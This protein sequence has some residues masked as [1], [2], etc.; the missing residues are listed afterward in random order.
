[1]IHL[2]CRCACSLYL[3]QGLLLPTLYA[4]G[5][6]CLSRKRTWGR[7]VST[8]KHLSTM[9]ILKS[10]EPSVKVQFWMPSVLSSSTCS[11]HTWT[12]YALFEFLDHHGFDRTPCPTRIVDRRLS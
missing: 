1:M 11:Y 8:I 9:T 10:I 12:L 7:S 3:Y 5:L 2:W 6:H 4:S